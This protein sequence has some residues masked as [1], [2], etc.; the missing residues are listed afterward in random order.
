MTRDLFEPDEPE[1]SEFVEVVKEDKG[2]NDSEGILA[3][4]PVS[5]YTTV[6]EVKPE[7]IVPFPTDIP[8]ASAEPEE[9]FLDKLAGH[10]PRHAAKINSS[11]VKSDFG[12]KRL[13]Y[14]YRK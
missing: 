2:N 9:D 1:E 13:F 6:P 11:I 10:P 12:Y 14:N 7:K 4:L 5:L 8:Q 3:R